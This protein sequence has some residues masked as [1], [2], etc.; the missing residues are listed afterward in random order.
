MFGSGY[1]ISE[2]LCQT[3]LRTAHNV[4]RRVDWHDEGEA[5]DAPEFWGEY[6]FSYLKGKWFYVWR[7]RDPDHPINSNGKIDAIEHIKIFDAYGYF[8]KKFE[9]VV[10]DMVEREMAD[11]DDKK[12]YRRNESLRGKFADEDISRITD[13]CLT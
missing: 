8:Q 13:Y 12:L 2:I 4:V 3:S 7:L 6:A 5:R 10:G 9:D 11:G 1:D